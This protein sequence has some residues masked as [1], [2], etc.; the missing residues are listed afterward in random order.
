M[1]KCLVSFMAGAVAIT[2]CVVASGLQSGA[3]V[4]LGAV[5]ATAIYGVVCFSLGTPRLIR[6]LEWISGKRVNRKNRA[7]LPTRTVV[8]RSPVE[9]D[10]IA[11][12]IQQGIGRGAAMRATS[13]AASKAPQ[14]FEPLFRAAL[15]FLYKPDRPLVSPVK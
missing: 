12:L 9:Q 10:V 3:L 6:F 2:A 5:V 4:L 14:Q 1:L 8:Q 13:D 11:A 15:N 7:T